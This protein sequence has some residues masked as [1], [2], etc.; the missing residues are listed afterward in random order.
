METAFA[1]GKSAATLL[2]HPSPAAELM[3]VTDASGTHVG[4]VLQ[5][6]CGQQAWRALGFFSQ[7]LSDTESRYSAFDRELLAVYSSILHFRHLLERRHFVVFSDH[8]PLAG[9]LT[10]VSDRQRRQLAFI[11]EFVS[12]IHHIAGTDNM[13]ADTLSS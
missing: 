4:A 12:E 8:K 1:A 11:A 10:R 3:L 7:K 13:V 6:Q 9:A 5:Q 2:D